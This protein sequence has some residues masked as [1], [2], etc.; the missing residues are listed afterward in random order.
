MKMKHVNIAIGLFFSCFPV[1]NA[2][3]WA[4]I[5]AADNRLT[6]VHA[7]YFDFN[8]KTQEGTIRV[9]DALGPAVQ[10]IFAELYEKRFPINAMKTDVQSDVFLAEEKNEPDLDVTAA[11][12]CR[13]LTDS[14]SVSLHAYGAAIDLNPREN[15]Y[16]GVDPATQSVRDIIPRDGWA[17]IN[18]MTYRH[19]KPVPIGRSEGVVDVF[20]RN[21]ILY[22]GGYWNFPIDYMH[23]EIGRENSM[24]LLAMNSGDAQKYFN[25]YTNFYNSCAA[26]FPSEY[27]EHRFLDLTAAL[28]QTGVKALVQY[29]NNPQ[30]FFNAATTM[31][32]NAAHCVSTPTVLQENSGEPHGD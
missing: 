7:Q 10:Q 24:L 20:A 2:V 27:A 23:F 6:V 16:L 9:L 18:R 29:Q 17:N 15:P 22:W 4:P 26:R 19:G 8:G 5:C 3:Q 32:V 30:A 14:A 1:A 28:D 21:G 31:A 25:I 11:F 12:S 13:L